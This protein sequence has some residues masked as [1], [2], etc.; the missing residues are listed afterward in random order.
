[1]I[2]SIALADIGPG[3]RVKV[4][5]TEETFI[6]ANVLEVHG[7]PPTYFTAESRYHGYLEVPASGVLEVLADPRTDEPALDWYLA[8]LEW[9]PVEH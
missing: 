7:E 8:D 3:A 5:E 6:V 4:R 2:A 9:V 1:M